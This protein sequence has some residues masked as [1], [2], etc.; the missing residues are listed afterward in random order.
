M[1]SSNP[2]AERRGDDEIGDKHTA[3]AGH[4]DKSL[5]QS[6][7]QHWDQDKQREHEGHDTRH[8]IALELVTDHGAGRNLRTG[9]AHTLQEPANEHHFQRLGKKRDDC[10]EE[11]DAKPAEKRLLAPECIG[12][13]ADDKFSKGHAE[14]EQ[15]DHVMGGEWRRHAQ[16][17]SDLPQPRQQSIDAE[18]GEG[19]QQGVENQAAAECHRIEW[20]SI[21]EWEV[22]IACLARG[23]TPLSRRI[24]W[25][26]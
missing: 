25:R 12:K 23:A 20:S 14:D 6:G 15:R 8:G 10:S 11:I 26:T 9:D 22:T 4:R 7:S 18:R 3:P 24:V 5:R 13:R 19:G 2:H 16:L 17:Q 1:P 21:R